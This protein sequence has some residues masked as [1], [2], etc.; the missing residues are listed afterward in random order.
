MIWTSEKKNHILVQIIF[1]VLC[2]LRKLTFLGLNI[3]KG[4]ISSMLCEM[5]DALY[6]TIIPRF[7]KILLVSWQM[8]DVFLIA[9]SQT[10]GL[11]A[12][13]SKC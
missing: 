12:Q 9:V 6:F 1:M 13:S 3:E 4:S 2:C 8:W 5:F 10:S 7:V 11:K